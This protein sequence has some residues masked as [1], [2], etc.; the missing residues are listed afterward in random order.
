MHVHTAIAVGARAR[1]YSTH[2]ARIFWRA[3]THTQ[4]PGSGAAAAAIVAAAEAGQ[5]KASVGP[6]V[7]KPIDKH[8]LSM[9][10]QLYYTSVT[11]ACSPTHL[12]F[13][14]CCTRWVQC[15]PLDHTSS[16]HIQQRMWCCDGHV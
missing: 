14:A 13:T 16:F 8:E 10:Q 1:V 15:C 7:L 2:D 9:E 6:V 11:K 12:A 5:A 4:L 3:R